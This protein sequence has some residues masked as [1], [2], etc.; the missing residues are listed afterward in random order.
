MKCLSFEPQTPS[1]TPIPYNIPPKGYWLILTIVS[2]YALGCYCIPLCSSGRLNLIKLVFA[3]LILKTHWSDL[4]SPWSLNPNAS[5]FEMPYFSGQYI[6]SLNMCQDTVKSRNNLCWSQTF[7][8]IIFLHYHSS[9]FPLVMN[10]LSDDHFL[11][12]TTRK[13]QSIKLRL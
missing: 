8:T 12:R 2:L 9:A 6:L 4:S 7:S 11:G 5:I 3:P 13:Y 1:S 10:I